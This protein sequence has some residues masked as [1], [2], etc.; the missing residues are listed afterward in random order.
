MS[1]FECL[2]GRILAPLTLVI[3]AILA[4]TA[5]QKG[6]TVIIQTPT[7]RIPVVVEVARTPEE[8]ATGLMHRQSLPEGHGMLFVYDQPSILSFWMKNTLIPL[9]ILF[10]GSD[11]KIKTIS[12]N[13]PPCPPDTACPSYKSSESV[14]YVLEVNGGVAERQK[15]GVGDTVDLSDIK[16]D[17]NCGWNRG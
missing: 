9:D 17:P 6:P 1:N 15:V 14:Q 3:V 4:L 8:K 11:L 13:T 7:A 10:I 5:C 12:E 16:L 2:K